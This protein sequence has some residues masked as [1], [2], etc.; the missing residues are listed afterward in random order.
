METSVVK[1]TTVCVLNQ[2]YKCVSLKKLLPD[3]YF[4]NDAVSVSCSSVNRFCFLNLN[5]T[6]SL[7]IRQKITR[8]QNRK[9]F[10]LGLDG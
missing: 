6:V 8:Y 9:A 10:S 3:K 4:I 2:G 7:K 5:P 1:F